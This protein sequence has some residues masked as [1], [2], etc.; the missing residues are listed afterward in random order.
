MNV[1]DIACNKT[2]QTSA[3]GREAEREGEREA[4]REG[5]RGREAE[6]MNE[7][8]MMTAVVTAVVASRPRIIRS[9]QSKKSSSITE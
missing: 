5:D 8:G 9:K 6:Q 1:Y 2:H 7:Q 4:E 3:S